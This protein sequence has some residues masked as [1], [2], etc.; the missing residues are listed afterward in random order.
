MSNVPVGRLFRAIRMHLA[1]VTLTRETQ[2][3]IELCDVASLKVVT[4]N[5]F[6]PL[7]VVD[8]EPVQL[9]QFAWVSCLL[10][11]IERHRLKEL[12]TVYSELSRLSCG[13]ESHGDPLPHKRV[14]D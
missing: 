11:A 12:C 1:S 14:T 4:Q 9:H 5:D 2:D 7:Q 13:A 6:I 3:V 10:V 8:G